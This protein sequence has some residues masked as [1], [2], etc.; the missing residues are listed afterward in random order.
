MGRFW[1]LLLFLIAGAAAAQTTWRFKV[2]A[3]NGNRVVVEGPVEELSVGEKLIGKGTQ[4][5]GTV[6]KL[7]EG[8]AL[9]EFGGGESLKIGDYLSNDIDPETRKR[10]AVDDLLKDSGKSGTAT[11]P[12]KP[13]LTEK[14]FEEETRP[15][16]LRNNVDM[17]RYFVPQQ[18]FALKL[19]GDFSLSNKTKAKINNIDTD[20]ISVSS[21]RVPIELHYGVARSFAIEANWNYLIKDTT[22]DTT[23]TSPKT[24]TTTKAHG[25]SDP[26]FSAK[27]R[28]PMKAKNLVA[29]FSVG[30]SPPIM[31]A[32]T[33]TTKADGTN[34]KGSTAL[35][36]EAALYGGSNMHEWGVGAAL[37][38]NTSSTVGANPSTSGYDLNSYSDF[39]LGTEYRFHPT[40]EFFI[41]PAFYLLIPGEKTYKFKTTPTLEDKVSSD[42]VPELWLRTGY[43]FS[44]NVVL[45]LRFLYASFS[46]TEKFSAGSATAT[47]NEDISRTFLEAAFIIEF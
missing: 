22:E 27:F 44:Q 20:D 18:R 12:E 26:S 30:F 45:Q 41:S 37:V 43:R 25:L 17:L 15:S 23:L 1:A 35:T 28:S 11:Q 21:V 46:A 8:M 19:G 42:T 13:V 3:V 47:V 2:S 14:A 39:V 34:G 40:E 4:T 24:V 36:G 10:M 9:V 32:D 29:D 31:R 5:P 7:K 33:A 38:V 6:I 16:A